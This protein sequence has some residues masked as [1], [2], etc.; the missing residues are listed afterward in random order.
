MNYQIYSNDINAINH[1][2]SN[3]KPLY[4]RDDVKV[5][6]YLITTLETDGD[7][8]HTYFHKI[9]SVS[10]KTFTI[11]MIAHDRF[12]THKPVRLTWIPQPFGGGTLS[13]KTNHYHARTYIS[14]KDFVITPDMQPY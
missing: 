9:I 14:E 13:N 4:T 1:A 7:M 11:Q 6:D 10:K 8:C 2:R 3:S 12:E 5:G